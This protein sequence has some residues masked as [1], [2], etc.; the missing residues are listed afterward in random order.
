MLGFLLRFI[1]NKSRDAKATVEDAVREALEIVAA[2]MNLQTTG[3]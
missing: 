1:K 3:F 2:A